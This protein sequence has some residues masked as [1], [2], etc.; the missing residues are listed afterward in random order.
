MEDIQVSKKHKIINI[1]LS[2]SIIYYPLVLINLRGSVSIYNEFIN[3]ET[4]INISNFLNFFSTL[5]LFNIRF[6][7]LNN[8]PP[9]FYVIIFL[10]FFFLFI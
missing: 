9:F 1:F 5:N 4:K 6:N 7:L 8:F 10:L 2:L 3:L